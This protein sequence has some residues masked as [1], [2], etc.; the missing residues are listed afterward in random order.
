MLGQTV[1]VDPAPTK[2]ESVALPVDPL[3]QILGSLMPNA[4]QRVATVEVA[5]KVAA[6]AIF[7]D[8]AHPGGAEGLQRVELALLHL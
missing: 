6:L 1:V 4:L 3:Q 2:R 5:H 8:L 7:P